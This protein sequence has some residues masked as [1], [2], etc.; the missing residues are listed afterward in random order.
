MY[1][2]MCFVLRL[3]RVAV[4][5]QGDVPARCAVF[6]QDVAAKRRVPGEQRL[7]YVGDGV[8]GQVQHQL[9]VIPLP[10]QAARQCGGNHHPGHG[11]DPHAA[12]CRHDKPIP[13]RE[14]AGPAEAGPAG[15]T[16]K[17]STQ[18]RAGTIE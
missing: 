5:E 12:A 10:G 3:Q 8:A 15:H 18:A 16:G 4:D 1:F 7:E 17:K 9:P 11:L 13:G 2:K 6:V 14:K